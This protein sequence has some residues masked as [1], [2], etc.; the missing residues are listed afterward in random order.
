[1]CWTCCAI[2]SWRPLDLRS[3]TARRSSRWFPR[4]ST[5]CR[6]R[7]HNRLFLRALS[8]DCDHSRCCISLFATYTSMSRCWSTI[9]PERKMQD[10][11]VIYR[12]VNFYNFSLHEIG[13]V[14]SLGSIA[15]CCDN[16]IL[17]DSLGSFFA[18]KKRYDKSRS[19][20]IDLSH[21]TGFKGS[22]WEIAWQIGRA[23]SFSY[24]AWRTRWNLKDELPLTSE[25]YFVFVLDVETR[26]SIVSY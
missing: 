21:A 24:R 26:W 3:P 17:P 19:P 22:R 9:Q 4:S 18:R 13:N 8:I 1:M 2:L 15:E 12:N 6:D 20:R 23:V 10:L 25:K 7:N 14:I 11:L 5:L 16:T